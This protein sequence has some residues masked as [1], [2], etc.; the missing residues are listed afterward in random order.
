MSRSSVKWTWFVIFLIDA[1]H[2]SNLNRIRWIICKVS[3]GIIWTARD[4]RRAEIQQ[5]ARFLAPRGRGR[6]LYS[7]LQEERP[8][9]W[10]MKRWNNNV[11]SG[12]FAI[13]HEVF[14]QP[15]DFHLFCGVSFLITVGTMPSLDGFFLEE[16]VETGVKIRSR[17]KRR[18]WERKHVENLENIIETISQLISGK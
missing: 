16:L 2:G 5:F 12:S 6:A 7:V 15:C 13:T 4:S 9:I 8:G 14:G 18:Y 3:F 10:Q 1:N 17:R 11:R